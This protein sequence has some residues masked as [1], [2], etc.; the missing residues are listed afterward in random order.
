MANTIEQQFFDEL[1]SD[2]FI[3]ETDALHNELFEQYLLTK[4]REEISS[5]EFAQYVNEYSTFL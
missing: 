5:P 4:H 3:D 2:M 1:M